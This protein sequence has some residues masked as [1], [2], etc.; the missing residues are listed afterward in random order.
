[1]INTPYTSDLVLIGGGHSHLAVVK[2]FAMNPLAGLRITLISRDIH[3]PYSGM[4]P[5]LIAG[6]YEFDE[7][8]IDLRRLCEKANVRLFHSSVT[9]I[10]LH[11]QQIICN[12]RTAVRYDW[13]SVNVG[14]QPDL[15][16]IAGADEHGFAVKPI[17]NFLKQWHF[18]QEKLRSKK[19]TTP[20][21]IS[22]VGG[23]AASVEV[24]LAIR[25][26]LD[27]SNLSEK[28]EIEIISSSE[29]LLPTHSRR[30]QNIMANV[31]RQRNIEMHNSRKVSSVNSVD[32]KTV[33]SFTN[34]PSTSTDGLIWAIH[35][36][37]PNWLAATG[38]QC[39]A[40]GFIAVNQYLQSCSHPNVFAAG[41][42]AHFTP[43][44][45]PKSGVYAVRGGV[46]L[47]NNLR[48]A[49][50]KK[51]L[52]PYKPQRHFLSLLITGDKQAIASKGPI[53]FKA[54]WLWM[55][56]DRID[57]QFMSQYNELPAMSGQPLPSNSTVQEAEP[58]RC[59]G[60]GAKIGNSVLTRV[61]SQLKPQ[62][63]SDVNIGL[64]H[65]DDAAVISPPEGKKWLQTV[66]YFR[67]FIDDPYLL[68]R[69]ATNHCL[70][71]IYAMGATPHS[72]LAVATVP[73]ANEALVEDTLL[74]L[75]SGAVDSL[76]EQDTALIGGHSSEGA[77][78][79]FGLSVNGT[80][81]QNNLLT[82][83]NLTCGL[84]LILTK[85]LG[86]GTLLAANMAGN[87]EG[88]W[89]DNALNHML[90]SNRCAADI[91][92]KNQALA[93]TDITG[94]GLLGHLQEMISASDA[95]II[96]RLEFSSI[97]VMEGVDHCL[98]NNWLSTLHPEN[99]HAQNSLINVEQFSTHKRYPI[100]YDPQTAG[101]LIA[102][103]PADR[104]Q[105]CLKELQN[106]DCPE[107]AIIGEV[108]RREAN[109]SATGNIFL[110]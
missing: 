52:K 89:V 53:S 19:R 33:L 103:I 20:F 10:D 88:R 63:N 14:S 108:A 72:A 11:R 3:T 34:S 31:L 110:Y 55:W 23:G 75:M 97:P 96:M 93:C 69:I 15:D 67:A 91:V 5:S 71:D 66:D 105:A 102:A 106:G 4:L 18:I 81:D 109:Q 58:M 90:I 50:E 80:C 44:A 37:S 51:A 22:V 100:L 86:S 61:I 12:N 59:G 1:M 79:G 65:P 98:Q 56:K 41:D 46:V 39:D 84:Q 49:I 87:A 99:L 30:A 32:E 82:K 35:A 47:A 104:A 60:C 21:K 25:Y 45:L 107:A 62:Q 68:G 83:G 57:R 40:M 101:G 2:H 13:L 36:G 7:T 29:Q 27:L 78:L 28:T 17:D 48:R 92:H 16:S 73:Y 9:D 94:F 54:K 74:Q 64:D 6:H 70:S 95:D 43:Q 8:H 76:N 38:L 42:I 85:P 77:E 24:A 26:R